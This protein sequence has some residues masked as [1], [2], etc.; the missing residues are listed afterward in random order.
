VPELAELYEQQLR[1]VW[2]C[3]RS[4][5]VADRDLDDA[6]QDLFLVVQKKLPEFDGGVSP[7]TWLYAI[8][9]RIA[10][11]YKERSTLARQRVESDEEQLNRSVAASDTEADAERQRRLALARLA[12]DALD[13]DKREAFVFSQIEQ[14]SANEIS[15]ITGVPVNTVYSRIRAAR[16]IFSTEVERLAVAPVRSK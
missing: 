11:R 13:D 2:R 15:E 3:L 12:L 4:L 16:A 7:K 6:I 10:R 8:A 9:I 14:M 1:Y 5:G